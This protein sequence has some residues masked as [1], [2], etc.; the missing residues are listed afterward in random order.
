LTLFFSRTVI[1]GDSRI[2]VDELGIPY[3]VAMTLTFPERVTSLNFEEMADRVLKG[4]YHLDGAKTVV[5]N[6][7]EMIM[8]DGD[9]KKRAAI[10]LEIGNIVER[11]LKD[12]DLLLLN[13]QP[14]LRRISFM[15]HKARRLKHKTFRLNLSV[16]VPYNAD[17]DGK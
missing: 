5:T 17:F 10:R 6:A 12:G 1:T 14:S 16:T 9:I 15:A 11:H 8:L 7:N 2:N 3:E 4:P 13:R